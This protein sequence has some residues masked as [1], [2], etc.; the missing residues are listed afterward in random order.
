MRD[1]S[2]KAQICQMEIFIYLIWILSFPDVQTDQYVNTDVV[3]LSEHNRLQ[4][5]LLE[6]NYRQYLEINIFPKYIE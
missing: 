6:T 4:I 3:M 1:S 5:S 2:W